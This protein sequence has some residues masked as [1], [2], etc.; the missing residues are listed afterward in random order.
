MKITHAVLFLIILFSCHTVTTAQTTNYLTLGTWNSEGVPNYLQQND[1]VSQDFLNWIRASVKDGQNV[2]RTHPE[3][4][5]DTVVTNLYVIQN[6]DVFVTFID[7]GAGYRNTLGFYTYNVNNPPQTIADI[8][9]TMTIIFPNSS[10]VNSGGGMRAGMKVKIGTFTPGTVIGWFIIADG[11]RSSNVTNGNWRLFS[12]PNLNPQTNTALKQQNLQLK[13][14]N[15]GRVVLTFEDIRRDYGGCDNDFE[16]VVFYVSANPVSAINYQNIPE[17][18]NPNPVPKA[19]LQLQKSVDD[20]TP[21]DNQIVNYTLTLRNNGPD[22]ATQIKIKDVL[23]AGLIYQNHTAGSGSYDTA[24]GFWD[25]PFL[26][27]QGVTTLSISAKVSIASISQS[28]F[29]LSFAKDFNVFTFGDMYQPSADAEGRVAVGRDAFFANYSVGNMLN[30][31]AG[32][33]DVLIV[34]RNLIYLS[35]SVYNGNVV[36]KDSTNLPINQVSIENGTLRKDSLINFEAAESYFRSLS[37]SLAQYTPNGTVT[38]QNSGLV[39]N[40]SHPFLNV[41]NVKGNQL[42]QST[43]FT[44]NVP[45]GSVALVNI[46]SASVKWS[47]GLVV[48]GTAT[49]NVLYNVWQ[50]EGLKI[51][52]IDLRG[53]L[54]APR[55]TL[56]FPGGVINGQVIVKSIYGPG[57]FNSGEHNATYFKGK[58]PVRETLL[59]SAEVISL[60]EQDPDSINNFAQVTVSL[61]GYGDPGQ[62]GN[63]NWQQAQGGQPAGDMIW[64]MKYGPD[65]NLY[66]GTWGGKVLRSTNNGTD[67]THINS[68]MLVGYLWDLEFESASVIYAATERGVY[69]TT[70]GGANWAVTALENVDVRTILRRG[71]TLYAGAWGT[72]VYRSANGGASWTAFNAGLTSQVVNAIRADGNGNLFA[73]TFGGGVFKLPSG[74][75]LWVKLN[76]GWDFI[77]SLGIDQNNRIYAGTYGNGMY[78]SIDGGNTWFMINRNLPATHIYGITIDPSNNVFITGWASGVYSLTPAAAKGGENTDEWGYTGLGGL[79]VSSVIFSP[80]TGSLIAGTSS[81]AVYTNNNPLLGIKDGSKLNPFEFSLLQNYPNPFNPATRISF[82]LPETGTVKLNVYNILGQLVKELYNGVLEAGE[83]TLNFDASGMPSGTYIYQIE[84]GNYISAR[85]M[86]LL[87]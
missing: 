76:T 45:N 24:T 19:D 71:G 41:F 72:G 80:V 36:Y 31:P 18:I 63:V 11:F 2:P 64:V 73:G 16:D 81:G 54:L 29:D 4:L 21:D 86:V 39:L 83:H 7:E 53:T 82:V 60:K 38:I 67:W 26:L 12:N 13:D 77:W 51:T 79:E 35:G 27:N 15:S 17:L 58:I 5:S 74:T 52:E 65:N 22:A 30:Y 61:T 34:G 69:K 10:K 57:Q 40:G 50:A 84:A 59:N 44:L 14:P 66:A 85:K 48:N 49:T 23:P 68:S 1:I 32:A 47:G 8:Q 28:A 75:S 9:N 43:S 46:D 3:W 56:D 78:R 42:S 25:V 33:E 62:T 70:D 55:A 6:C 37:L 87:K 20:N